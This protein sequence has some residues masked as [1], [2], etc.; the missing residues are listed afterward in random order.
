V[1]SVDNPM[2]IALQAAELEDL[3]SSDSI[4][5]GALQSA[6]L[7]SAIAQGSHIE[8]VPNASVLGDNKLAATF[9]FDFKA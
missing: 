3:A 4:R 2:L 6:V 1:F 9:R 8:M 7:R 5:T